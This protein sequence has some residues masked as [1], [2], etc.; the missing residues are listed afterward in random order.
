MI[1]RLLYKI[2]LF[3]IF[4]F[5]FIY[6]LFESIK[7]RDW[8]FFENKFGS[9][10]KTKNINNLCIHCASLGEV[11]GAR[12]FINE[13]SKS[14]NIV[15][16]TNTIS[17]KNRAKELFPDLDIVYFPFDYRFIVGLWLKNLNVKTVLIYETE[18][19]PNFYQICYEN[20]INI[21]VIN[22]RISKHIISGSSFIK[23]NYKK[24][25]ACCKI[26]LCKSGYEKEKYESIGVEE[27]K[28]LTI[29]NLKYSY[30]PDYTDDLSLVRNKK[31]YE[32]NR[33]TLDELDKYSEI[34]KL[35]F[36]EKTRI[37]EN[38]KNKYLLM[39]S[40]HYP[41]EKYFLSLIVDLVTSGFI[42]VI[43]PR[44][45]ERANE[46]YK[47]FKSNNV[48]IHIFSELKENKQYLDE[49]FSGVLILDTF[50]DLPKFYYGARLIYVGGGYSKRGVQNIIEP[51]TYG[52]PIIVG[53]N[54][55]NFYEEI[56]NLRKDKG[57]TIIEDDKWIPVQQNIA[58]QVND[59]YKLDDLVLDQM[60]SI[61][62]NYT[63]KFNDVLDNYLKILK[64][65]KI[66][67]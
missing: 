46:I 35:T 56:I 64:E 47:F 55:D 30:I 9:I 5:V 58:K 13:T 32:K 57:I 36:L 49:K 2:I 22:A 25:L 28:L 27:K 7:Q 65:Q 34:N 66:I 51:S 39:A 54:I 61:A 31:N 29:G 52:R 1:Y 63:L 67:N 44:H 60:G 16:S 24:A 19:W 48:A 43:A 26:I 17:G 21:A 59:I 62:K 18:I 15:I 41:D 33:K 4:P 37:H 11:N 45:I 8:N 42:V 38:Q 53:P 50:G 23:E 12:N 20:G 10:L 3:L 6:A 14:N 40:T